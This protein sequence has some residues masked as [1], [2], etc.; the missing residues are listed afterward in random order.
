[1]I[2]GRIEQLGPPEELYERPRTSF[3]ARFLGASNLLPGT[4][5]EPGNVRLRSGAV[6]R[7]SDAHALRGASVGV[8]IRPEK[9][10]LDAAREH[11]SRLRGT[12][13]ERSYVGVA[14]QYIVETP[15]GAV[16]VFVQNAE[17]RADALEPGAEVALSFD[18]DAAFVVES[19]QEER[20]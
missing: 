17:P 19:N 6:V 15:D 10:R 13:T 7:V 4:V 18:P 8:G 11:Q 16:S 12:V 1:M 5:E 3:V 9:L 2:G 20:A 14:T